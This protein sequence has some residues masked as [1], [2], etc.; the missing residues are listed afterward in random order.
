V[1][2]V[3][4]NVEHPRERSSEQLRD[5]GANPAGVRDGDDR[6]TRDGRSP[7]NVAEP[8]ARAIRQGEHR[9]AAG[10]RDFRP[11]L[12]PRAETLVVRG[13]D[14]IPEPAVPRSEIEL[15]NA[16]IELD[17]AIPEQPEHARRI[18]RAPQVARHD[19]R[20]LSGETARPRGV[21]RRRERANRRQARRRELHVRRPDALAGLRD[22]SAVAHKDEIHE[23]R[24][25]IESGRAAS[26]R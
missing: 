2:E 9:F 6:L 21:P 13:V 3:D 17:V 19:S 1:P 26:A 7:S 15:A 11:S 22:R 25:A 10:R 12:A 20:R 23:A 5:G 8:V 16:T 24:Q 14:R 4:W 18:R